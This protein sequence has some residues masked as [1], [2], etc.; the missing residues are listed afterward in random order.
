[1]SWNEQNPTEG[2]CR[3]RARHCAVSACVHAIPADRAPNSL[4]RAHPTSPVCPCSDRGN[5]ML[6]RRQALKILRGARELLNRRARELREQAEQ[7]FRLVEAADKAELA[8]GDAEAAGGSVGADATAA[9]NGPRQEMAGQ[10]EAAGGVQAA[11]QGMPPPPPE[12]QRQQQQQQQGAQPPLPNQQ[13]QQ[14]PGVGSGQHAPAQPGVRGSGRSVDNTSASGAGS[15]RQAPQSGATSCAAASAAATAAG[16]ACSVDALVE[17]EEEVLEVPPEAPLRPDPWQWGAKSGVHLLDT[18]EGV[19]QLCTILLTPAAAASPAAAQ[20]QQQQRAGQQAAVPRYDFFGFHFD[21]VSTGSAAGAA[22]LLPKGTTAAQRREHAAHDKQSGGARGAQRRAVTRCSAAQQQRSAGTHAATRHL[23]FC[24]TSALPAARTPTPCP[25]HLTLPQVWACG[26]RAWPSAGAAGRR[27]T[28]RCTAG[29]A[30]GGEASHF[31]ARGPVA[32]L[33]RKAS[34]GLPCFLACCHAVSGH[35]ADTHASPYHPCPAL[36]CPACLF[37]PGPTSLLSW[38][39]CL[40]RRR[41]RR[42][43]GTCAAS[44]RR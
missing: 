13:Q 43:P 27:F 16:E 6:V 8:H 4:W 40:G 29:G 35:A 33:Q 18:P 37:L 10:M 7:A 34:S 25:S 19:R 14:A 15:W 22:A 2:G 17:D 1:M 28:C 5:K 3:V 41:W 24:S 31:W 26:W 9:A 44:W 12:P 38:R 30:H 36:P 32:C 42:P 20:Q 11:Q 21:T 39:R 23:G